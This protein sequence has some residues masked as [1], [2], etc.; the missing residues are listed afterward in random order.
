MSVKQFDTVKAFTDFKPN[1][2]G[3]TVSALRNA[4]TMCFQCNLI[5]CGVAS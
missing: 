3:N 1:L 5:T 4:K 2:I